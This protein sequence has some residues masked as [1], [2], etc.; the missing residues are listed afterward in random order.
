MSA[1]N[2]SQS[3]AFPNQNYS[4]MLLATYWLSHSFATKI[5]TVSNIV[6][7]IWGFSMFASNQGAP[8]SSKSEATRLHHLPHQENHQTSQWWEFADLEQPPGLK[9]HAALTGSV[10]FPE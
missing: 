7:E 6:P 8:S 5:A 3:V 4:C 1:E 9:H 10:V 2:L